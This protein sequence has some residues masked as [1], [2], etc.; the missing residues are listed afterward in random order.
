MKKIILLLLLATYLPEAIAQTRV[1]IQAG[2]NENTTVNAKPPYLNPNLKDFGFSTGGYLGLTIDLPVSETLFLQPQFNLLYE[3]TGGHGPDN[4]GMSNYRTSAGIII[5]LEL[6]Y[7]FQLTEKLKLSVSA[8]PY[9]QLN[10]GGSFKY[11][12]KNP[13]NETI[14]EYHKWDFYVNNSYFNHGFNYG[15][16]GGVTL[17]QNRLFYQAKLKYS[18]KNNLLITSY[19]H[20]LGLSLGMGYYF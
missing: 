17:H 11:G 20:T 13:E 6:G 18:L 8:G 10:I 3:G 16:Q 4:S 14:K 1:G 19:G 2:I 5:P 15:V 12:V 9:A 7:R